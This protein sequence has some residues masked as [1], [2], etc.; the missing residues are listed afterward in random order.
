MTDPYFYPIY[1]EA[2]RLDM[3]IAIHIANGNLAQCDLLRSFP[4]GFNTVA[5]AMFRVPTVVTCYL[6]LMGE[7]PRVFPQLRWGMIE[8]SAQWMPWVHHEVARRYEAAGQDVPSDLFGDHNIFVTCQTDDD[9]PYAL[10]YAG[11]RSLVIGTDYG[12]TDP[13]SEV[14]AITIF[15]QRT[16]ISQETKERIL[17]HNAKAL[18]RL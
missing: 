3:A 4:E 16:D 5:F 14:D 10:R 17:Y 6:L 2:S 9:L 7:L 18:Y 11:E 8:S 13:S 15:R 12:H 1:E